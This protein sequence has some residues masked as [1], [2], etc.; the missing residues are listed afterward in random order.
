MLPIV[1]NA[2]IKTRPIYL[3]HIRDP[4]QMEQHPKME[5]KNKMT[6][7]ARGRIF[8]QDGR[9]ENHEKATLVV[10]IEKKGG[11]VYHVSKYNFFIISPFNKCFGN[12]LCTM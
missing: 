4:L 10:W 11:S 7:N 2:T 3:L 6:F 5:N 12:L 8:K 1:S 9:R